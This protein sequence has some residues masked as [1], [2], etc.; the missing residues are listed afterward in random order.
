MNTPERRPADFD[1]ITVVGTGRGIPDYLVNESLP[2]HS[3]DDD[4]LMADIEVLMAQCPIAFNF[5]SN[6][7]AGMNEQTKRALLESIYDHLG[8]RP[9][10][11]LAP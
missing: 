8:I 6:D 11:H 2:D 5:R 9:L 10:K 1:E 4:D 7:L 3:A